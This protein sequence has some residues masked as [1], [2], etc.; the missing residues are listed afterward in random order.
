[1]IKRVEIISDIK[2]VPKIIHT[3]T[4]KEA[5]IKADMYNCKSSRKSAYFDLKN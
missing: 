5:L 3:V 2:I 1:M 4:M